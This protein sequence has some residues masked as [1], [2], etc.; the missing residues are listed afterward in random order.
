MR[1]LKGMPDPF[2]Y[3]F[4]DLLSC[5][6]GGMVLI[7]IT[8]TGQGDAYQNIPDYSFVQVRQPRVSSYDH[9]AFIE[10][11]LLMFNEKS[12]GIP[13]TSGIANVGNF[14]LVPLGDLKWSG[15]TLLAEPNTTL[16]QSQ[17]SWPTS[18]D[19]QTL[20]K[21]LFDEYRVVIQ[22]PDSADAADGFTIDASKIHRPLELRFGF[23]LCLRTNGSHT[24]EVKHQ[25]SIQNRPSVQTWSSVF[26]LSPSNKANWLRSNRLRIEN[27][28][29]LSSAT[30][31]QQRD[32]FHTIVVR[33][34]PGRRATVV[35]FDQP[36]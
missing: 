1:R 2:S 17:V 22:M 27:T 32:V 14:N 18:V 5:A 4:I 6:L 34:S 23:F 9:F 31:L 26:D 29:P 25:A 13:D 28:A 20:S 10:V 30:S 3:S 24:V 36:I 15:S 12:V 21:Y 35:T 7:V 16:P 33:F 11:D 8:T 19:F